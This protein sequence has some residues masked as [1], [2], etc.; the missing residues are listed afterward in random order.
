MT[1][2]KDINPNLRVIIIVLLDQ[3]RQKQFYIKELKGV[4]KKAWAETPVGSYASL[5]DYVMALCCS[6]QKFRV[7]YEILVAY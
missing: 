3:N 2:E 1:R 7:S 6:H 4:I 5:V